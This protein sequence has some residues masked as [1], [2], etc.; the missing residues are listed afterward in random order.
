[1]RYFH[2][3]NKTSWPFVIKLFPKIDSSNEIESNFFSDFFASD[4]NF[5]WFHFDMVYFIVCPQKC[6]I[7]G[8]N[9]RDGLKCLDYNQ[10]KTPKQALEQGG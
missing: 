10:N 4:F 2:H 3:L 7:P 5:R 8:Q 9:L 6:L 1:M